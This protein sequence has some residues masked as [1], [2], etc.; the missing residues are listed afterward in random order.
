MCGNFQQTQKPENPKT[1]WGIS[2]QSSS[3]FRWNRSIGV[4]H[5][6]EINEDNCALIPP[7]PAQK[8]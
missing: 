5:E 3:C 8:S 6:V 1:S 7:Q 2:C 4:R